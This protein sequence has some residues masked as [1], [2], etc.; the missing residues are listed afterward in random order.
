MSVSNEDGGSVILTGDDVEKLSASDSKPHLL[1][2]VNF[3]TESLS[4]SME[5]LTSSKRLSRASANT[6]N[7]MS[8]MTELRCKR[9]WSDTESLLT[10]DEITAEVENRRQSMAVD[11]GV[12]G[13]EAWTKVERDIDDVSELSDDGLDE[14][15]DDDEEHDESEEETGRTMTCSSGTYWP[16]SRWARSSL[17]AFIQVRSGSRVHSLEPDHLAKSILGWM[18]QTGC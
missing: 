18:P 1:P 3:P 13:A 14:V 10:V 11:M 8:F 2:P 12:E 9:D 17:P 5:S 6:L 16:F 4:E 7:R 15:D